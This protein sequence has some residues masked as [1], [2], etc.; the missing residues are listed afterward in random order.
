MVT[1]SGNG[2]I[3]DTS[4]IDETEYE[5][6]PRQLRS[7]NTM[8]KIFKDFVKIF[9]AENEKTRKLIRE[10]NE[11]TRKLLNELILTVK[12]TS[13]QSIASQLDT[14]R[15]IACKMEQCSN[16]TLKLL[17][18]TLSCTNGNKMKVEVSKVKKSMQAEWNKKDKLRNELFWKFHC[19]QR[20]EEIYTLELEKEKTNLPRKFSPNFNGTES[21]EEKEI[22][23]KLAKEKVRTELKLQA[24]ADIKDNNNQSNR[25]ILI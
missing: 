6:Q 15:M 17:K 21:S 12:D 2:K 13:E 9:V 20:I 24:I 3:D 4:S 10:E 25:S 19:N 5:D 16:D 23:D 7:T 11:K 22:M 1:H 8:D 18:E 14:S